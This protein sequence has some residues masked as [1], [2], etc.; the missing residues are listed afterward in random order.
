MNVPTKDVAAR[1]ALSGGISEV[2]IYKMV[3]QVLQ[4]RQIA[5]NRRLLDIGCGVGNLRPYLHGLVT[6]YCG[7]DV[8]HYQGFPAD[9]P[10]YSVNLDEQRVALPDAI[11]DIVTAVE[12]IEHLENPRLLMRELKRLTR[13]GGLIIITTPNN[14]SFLS[15]LTL[16]VKNQFQAFQDS[17]Y[18]AHI[19]PLLE[20]DLLRIARECELQT[21]QI[22]YS[23]SGRIP[24]TPYHWPSFCGGRWFSD[25][26]LLAATRD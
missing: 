21:I 6:E 5:G 1:A 19:T 13:P 3:A 9:C 4:T 15:K 18:P 11:A 24:G 8:T 14:L 12:V 17:C 23:N 26:I 7:A 22:A 16:V 2:A 10:F 20:I 25:N